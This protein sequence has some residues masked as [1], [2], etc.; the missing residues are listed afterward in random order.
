MEKTYRRDIV[1]GNVKQFMSRSENGR[2]IYS[3]HY[4]HSDCTICGVVIVLRL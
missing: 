3:T 1:A 4:Y 2:S